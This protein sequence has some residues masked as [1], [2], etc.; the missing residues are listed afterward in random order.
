MADRPL[1]L[2]RLASRRKR[3]AHVDLCLDD[4]LADAHDEA[5]QAL[6]AA[7]ATD[8]RES[9]AKTRAAL[10]AARAADETA[11][12]AMLAA[13][14]RFTFQP[15]S[16]AAYMRLIDE[17]PPTDKQIA[18]VNRQ[19]QVLGPRQSPIRVPDFDEHTFAPAL[20]A[21]CLVEPKLTEAEVLD[22]WNGE[23]LTTAELQ[24]LFLTANSVNAQTR[25][26]ELGKGSGSTNGSARS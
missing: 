11:H 1:V 16:R 5:R 20:V 3:V 17:H 9:T 19:N 25:V 21:A 13:S 24:L 6:R 4:D 14:Q 10:K 23:G 7:E 2:D 12:E 18:A 15:I 8:A 26:V 22:L